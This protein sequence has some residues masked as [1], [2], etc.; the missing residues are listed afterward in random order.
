[1]CH[2]IKNYQC[3][4]NRLRIQDH[5]ISVYVCLRTNG[6]IHASVKAGL[7]QRGG[8]ESLFGKLC[9]KL[10][11]KSPVAC[12]SSVNISAYNKATTPSPVRA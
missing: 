9:T 1:M 5:T 12:R 11:S 3:F 6:S 2:V 4:N 10:F 8:R 7:F